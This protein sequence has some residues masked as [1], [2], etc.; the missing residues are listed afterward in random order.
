[1]EI[2]SSFGASCKARVA[3]FDVGAIDCCSA[4]VMS[5]DHQTDVATQ[6]R[7]WWQAAK[8][9]ASEGRYEHA[10]YKKRARRFMSSSG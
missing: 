7:S 4:P 1:M 3:G 10:N 9:T 5:V 8:P 2:K 6:I